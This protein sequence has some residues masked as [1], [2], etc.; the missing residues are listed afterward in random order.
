MM[1]AASSFLAPPG[2]RAK[3]GNCV[4]GPAAFHACASPCRRLQGPLALAHSWRAPPPTA[5]LPAG[6]GRFTR[7]VVTS[8]SAVDPRAAPC[9]QGGGSRRRHPHLNRAGDCQ[10]ADGSC[11]L[12]RRSA[13]T[14]NSMSRD[15]RF[16]P[17]S[18]RLVPAERLTICSGGTRPTSST[19]QDPAG[20]CRGHRGSRVS[21]PLRLSM[22]HHADQRGLRR[23]QRAP[24]RL[25][26]QLRPGGWSH[27]RRATTWRAV[28]QRQHFGQPLFGSLISAAADPQAPA[29][30]EQ[31]PAGPEAHAVGGNA[32]PAQ[33]LKQGPDH[34]AIHQEHWYPPIVRQ[35]V[36]LLP[37]PQSKLVR[38]APPRVTH[39][40]HVPASVRIGTQDPL[41]RWLASRGTTAPAGPTAGR[42]RRQNRLRRADLT[43]SPAAA[44]DTV[45]GQA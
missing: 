9:P 18:P 31:Q 23:D 41:A 16:I 20:T 21:G 43:L 35:A 22:P 19:S 12:D 30:R 36:A 17:Q 42:L 5:R 3:P 28:Q 33:F 29:C 24:G 37:P 32:C 34:P 45:R 1:R 10:M 7:I 2:C 40:A 27:R 13:V 8:G 38:R 11:F 39:S 4:I 44:E 6:V 15:G 26:P 14:T 25:A